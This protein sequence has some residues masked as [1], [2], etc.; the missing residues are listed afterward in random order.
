[1]TLFGAG[2]HLTAEK[3]PNPKQ[4]KTVIESWEKKETENNIKLSY[5][6]NVVFIAV[7]SFSDFW[8]QQVTIYKLAL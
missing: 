8:P 3:R 7:V 2:P 1:M 5:E 4:L 6:F